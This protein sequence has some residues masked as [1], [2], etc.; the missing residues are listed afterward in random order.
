VNQGFGAAEQPE[1]TLRGYEKALNLLNPVS[2]MQPGAE[3][4]IEAGRGQ[5]FSWLVEPT[6][7]PRT[8]T[9]RLGLVAAFAK[10]RGSGGGIEGYHPFLPRG[11]WLLSHDTG[12]VR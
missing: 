5:S 8:D 9:L 4:R 10:L 1:Y 11:P 2:N 3:T 12:C 6:R 7:R